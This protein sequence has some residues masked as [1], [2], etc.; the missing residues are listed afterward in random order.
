MLVFWPS[1]VNYCPSNFLSSSPPKNRLYRQCVTGWGCG[2]DGLC[3]RPCICIFCRSLILCI[4]PDSE[5]T[6][7]LDHPKQKPIEG[8][9]PRTDKHLPQNPFTG[10]FFYMTTFYIAFYQ[11]NLLLILWTLF[12]D[13]ESQ[14]LNSRY[15]I[16][17]STRLMVDPSF[18]P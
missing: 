4:W 18:C 9:G 6:K 13:W 1:F 5:P 2:G 16:F 11:S 15:N 12:M 8:R 17:S 10:K 7:L 3:W 14:N